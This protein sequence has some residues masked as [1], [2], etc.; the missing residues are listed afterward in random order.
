MELAHRVRDAKDLAPSRPHPD[1]S[2]SALYH[3]LVGPGVGLVDP[4]PR[5]RFGGR[6]HG[7]G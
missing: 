4:P 1:S 6:P 2:D 3:R 7:G 5:D